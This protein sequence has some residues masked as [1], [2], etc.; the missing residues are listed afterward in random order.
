MVTGLP[1][2]GCRATFLRPVPLF[3]RQE[4]AREFS[5][6][7]SLGQMIAIRSQVVLM[8]LSMHVEYSICNSNSDQ[9]TL[10]PNAVSAI[11]PSRVLADI[12]HLINCLSN[13][14]ILRFHTS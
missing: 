9:S 5:K 4:T 10:S 3:E 8:T 7:L 14:H 1:S 2:Y 6:T 13:D 12:G 11:V